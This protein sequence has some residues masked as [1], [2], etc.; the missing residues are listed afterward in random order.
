[1]TILTKKNVSKQILIV[2]AMRCY[3]VIKIGGLGEE[4]LQ[5]MLQIH[6]QNL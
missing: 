4:I 1:M 6:N 2:L 5:R 3:I